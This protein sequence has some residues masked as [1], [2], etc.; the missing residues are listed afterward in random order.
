MNAAQKQL[1]TNDLSGK[2]FVSSGRRYSLFLLSEMGLFIRY[3]WNVWC[4]TES[5]STSWLCW[6]YR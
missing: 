4:S 2:V 6:C 5:M 1:G 3:G